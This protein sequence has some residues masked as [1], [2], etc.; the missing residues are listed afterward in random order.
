MFNTILLKLHDGYPELIRVNF[1]E[2]EYTFYWRR[3]HTRPDRNQD[4]FPYI[5]MESGMHCW[6]APS[7][8]RHVHA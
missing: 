2:S 8:V 1:S 3:M 4:H 6:D 7:S 5:K